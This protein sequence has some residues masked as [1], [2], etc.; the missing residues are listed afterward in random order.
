MCTGTRRR[1]G[2]CK[3]SQLCPQISCRDEQSEADLENGCEQGEYRRQAG[4]QCVGTSDG[5]G[6][7]PAVATGTLRARCHKSVAKSSLIGAPQPVRDLTDS[8]N[9]T[10]NVSTGGDAAFRQGFALKFHLLSL[11]KGR[12][13]FF[14]WSERSPITADRFTI[15]IPV[16]IKLPHQ[17]WWKFDETSFNSSL[18]FFPPPPLLDEVCLEENH[19]CV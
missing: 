16:N 11:F 18:F 8:R 13:S 7:G 15:I 10:A 3:L 4:R 17:F 19:N 5:G 1:K 12:D 6:S 9:I 2:A 14:F